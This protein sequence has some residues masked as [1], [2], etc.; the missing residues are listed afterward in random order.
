[1]AEMRTEDE[2]L[3]I[4][5]R[6]TRKWI[7]RMIAAAAGSGHVG[8]SL[9][10]V[11]IL[12]TLFFRQMRIDPHNPCWSERDRV[13]LS[14]AHA[15]PTLYSVLALRGY[16][17][18]DE[19]FTLDQP[20]TRLSKHVD[21]RKLP[22][23]DSSGGMLG[24]GL[25]VGVGMALGARIIGNPSHIYSILGD[26]ELQSGQ[27]WEAAMCAAK[28]HLSNLTAIVDRNQLQFDG[29]TEDVMP[30]EPLA[31]KWRAFGWQVLEVD[32]HDIEQLLSAYN[33]ALACKT[34]PTVIIANTIKGQGV[35]FAQG[36]V[37]WH[38]HAI[39][40][41]ECQIAM[42]ELDEAV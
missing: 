31:T 40:Q 24:Q 23:C 18:T 27:I 1:M 5:C 29:P 32:G 35:S 42:A 14:K 41:T 11:E 22:A 3:K 2:E 26:G 25:S 38:S 6:E 37:S 16:L 19:L 21:R 28:Y 8:G 33:L 10:C 20:P 30:I 39:S 17:S 34:Q 36:Q 13:I 4:L 15:G 12:V 9:S 7:V